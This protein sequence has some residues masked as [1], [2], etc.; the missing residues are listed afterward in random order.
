MSEVRVLFVIDSLAQG[1]AERSSVLTA[2]HF[3]KAGWQVDFAI[4]NPEN[5]VC[6]EG[7]DASGIPVHVLDWGYPLADALKLRTVCERIDPDVVM[8]CLYRTALRVRLLRLLRP[9][10]RIVESLVG[11]AHSGSIEQKGYW[12]FFKQAV[13]KQIDRISA[14]VAGQHYHAIS[15]AVSDYYEREF[16]LRRES[17]HVVHRGREM[18]ILLDASERVRIRHE[19]FNVG[20]DDILIVTVGRQELPKNHLA[21]VNCAALLKKNHA[22]VPVVFAFVG[23]DGAST[24]AIN[25]AIR[26]GGTE[27]YFR[28]TG[29]RQ[30]VVSVI[31]AA[32]AFVLP[33]FHE[34]L[35]G[36]VIEAMSVG[37][38]I[39]A[40]DI[41]A[42]R[43]VSAG[44]P[45]FWF[46]S[47]HKPENLLDIVVNFVKNRP[48]SVQLA[49][50]NIDIFRQKFQA[51]M[52]MYSM[53]GMVEMIVRDS[54]GAAERSH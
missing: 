1:G 2:Q 14:R 37:L 49:Q 40:S 5:Q 17:I 50:S 39:F 7:L 35:S 47:P 27:E 4:F 30:D 33:S 12:Q 8:F 13:R 45:G 10:T 24:K 53:Q 34:G 20:P 52:I 6:R 42:V 19:V 31:Q 16:G 51:E 15:K 38:P 26:A 28:H 46:F 44:S 32:D 22:S 41:P 29:F 54:E 9:K 3:K 48:K 25:S 43:E 23:R 11:F 36:A 18:P 21:L